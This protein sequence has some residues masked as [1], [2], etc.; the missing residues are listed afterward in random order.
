MLP[1]A[2]QAVPV[3]HASIWMEDSG[4]R[5]RAVGSARGHSRQICNRGRKGL[6]SHYGLL[7]CSLYTLRGEPQG[8]PIYHVLVPV[9]KAEIVALVRRAVQNA[10]SVKVWP[11][12]ANSREVEG[13]RY[14]R[15]YLVICLL[16]TSP[17]PRD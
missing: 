1:P 14:G 5:P 7:R 4:V 6:R 13:P 15:E 3:S 9:D 8:R 17:S 10:E 12:E 11:N 16:Y 2:S